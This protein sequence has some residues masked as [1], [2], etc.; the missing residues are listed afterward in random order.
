MANID[1]AVFFDIGATLL[2]DDDEWIPGARATLDELRRRQVR[3]GLISN[4]G[5]LS[6]A[7]LI[8]ELPADFDLPSYGALALLSSEIGI[9]KPDLRIFTLARKR[10]AVETVI[11]CSEN[12]EHCLAAQRA[13]LL[14]LRVNPPAQSDISSLI[15]ILERASILS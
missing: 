15:G 6:R 7:E 12:L 14:V 11:F 10:A 9:E 8:A 4:T 1:V 5:S 3:L 13:G 2:T